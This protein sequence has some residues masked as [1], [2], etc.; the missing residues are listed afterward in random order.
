MFNIQIIS[1][2]MSLRDILTVNAVQTNTL[3]F[4]WISQRKALDCVININTTVCK[5]D[6]CVKLWVKGW[7]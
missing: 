1:A 6:D 5:E 4:I 3:P 7:M 2:G